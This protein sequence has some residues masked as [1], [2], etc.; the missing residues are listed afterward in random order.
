MAGAMPENFPFE[1]QS[2]ATNIKSYGFSFTNDDKLLAL[3][4]DGIA[5]EDDPGIESEITIP[6]FAG[7]TVTAV[8]VLHGFEQQLITSDNDGNL[9]IS[10]LLIKDY[11]IILRLSDIVSP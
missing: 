8:D 5:V 10:G 6:D 11:P 9:V 7:W 1:I 4:S 3:W 2:E